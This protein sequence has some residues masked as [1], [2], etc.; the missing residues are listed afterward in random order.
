[1]ALIPAGQVHSSFSVFE[2]EWEGHPNF[3]GGSGGRGQGEVDD[4]GQSYTQIHLEAC[5]QER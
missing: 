4:R 3:A 5:L 2:C 1:M